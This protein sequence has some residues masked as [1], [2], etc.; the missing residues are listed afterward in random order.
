MNEAITSINL[1]EDKVGKCM[2]L[3][4]LQSLGEDTNLSK[5]K[6]TPAAENMFEKKQPMDRNSTVKIPVNPGRSLMS[7][8]R[9]QQA[10]EKVTQNTNLGVIHDEQ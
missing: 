6:S 10:R 1:A 3:M 4:N 5:Y 2:D 9:A 8:P 7:D